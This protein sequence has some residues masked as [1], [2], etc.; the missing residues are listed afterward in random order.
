MHSLIRDIRR[1]SLFPNFSPAARLALEGWKN[2]QS[3][4]LGKDGSR[5]NLHQT[6]PRLH[7]SSFGTKS[8]AADAWSRKGSS[9]RGKEGLWKVPVTNRYST[10]PTACF[11]KE[12]G[13]LFAHS[14]SQTGVQALA[15]HW[16][17][18]L[19]PAGTRVSSDEKNAFNR[20]SLTLLS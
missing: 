7:F 20:L 15:Q 2:E 1:T 11:E 13:T 17:R 18:W 16:Q 14:I 5:G 19:P 3:E 8:S 10:V 9:S 12:A 6:C 4:G